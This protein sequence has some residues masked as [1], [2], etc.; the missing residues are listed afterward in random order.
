MKSLEFKFPTY[1]NEVI[2]TFNAHA[3]KY[4]DYKIYQILLILTDGCIHDMDKVKR[5][6]VESSHLPTSIIIVGIG[7][8]DFTLMEDLDSDKGLL[9]DD[10]GNEA[11]RD[12]VQ[13]VTFNEV[14]E[15]GN[16][17]EIVLKEVPN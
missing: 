17:A 5:L 14:K 15:R 3:A 2:S 8:E 12:I 6:I 16:L 11:A 1:F 7:D 9:K 4:K 13:F 10:D